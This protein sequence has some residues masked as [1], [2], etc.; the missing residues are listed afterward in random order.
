MRALIQKVW[1]WG[2]GRLLC[3]FQ[4][5]LSSSHMQ[6]WFHVLLTVYWPQIVKGQYPPA[7]SSRSRELRELIDRMLTLSAER[8]PSINEV[9]ATPLIKAR[10]TKFLSS[11]LQAHEFSHTIIHGRPQQGQ[12]VVQ[13]P[14]SAPAGGGGGGEVLPMNAKAAAGAAI[15][16]VLP[17][18]AVPSAANVAARQKA[19]QEAAAVSAAK[20]RAA[21]EAKEREMA[22]RAAREREA[23]VAAAAAGRREEEAKRQREAAAV[24]AQREM[25]RLR[26]EEQRQRIEHGQSGGGR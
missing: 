25:E 13:H 4:L 14:V 11:T 3:A 23:V 2:F 19:Q 20:A 9:L 8:R 16:A 21:Q 10:I 26:L 24:A 7:P 1:G 15:G 12:L 18:A 5:V 22:A 6:D 17:V